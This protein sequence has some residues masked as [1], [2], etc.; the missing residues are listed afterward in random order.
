MQHKSPVF[1]YLSYT[2]Y[3]TMGC[4][5]S[6]A[7]LPEESPPA[8]NVAG[9]VLVP[10]PATPPP[11]PGPPSSTL[12]RPRARGSPSHQST[13]HSTEGP[14]PNR[15][16]RTQSTARRAPS[17]KLSSS[18]DRRTGAQNVFPI[19]VF[20][21]QDRRSAQSLAS[22]KGSSSIPRPSNLG[23]S[24]AWFRFEPSMTGV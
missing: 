23:E 20:S 14:C 19:Q 11:S 2:H 22:G 10:M 3:R 8:R 1:T 12:P 18:E 13:P 6:T 16:T 7:N 9:A 21:S 24:D 4:C 15:R 5:G 17:T